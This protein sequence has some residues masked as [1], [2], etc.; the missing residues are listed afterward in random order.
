MVS[1]GGSVILYD[2]VQHISL[3]GLYLMMR[4]L[5]IARTCLPVTD[6]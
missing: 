3:D 1:I 6:V 4:T 5:R 2:Y